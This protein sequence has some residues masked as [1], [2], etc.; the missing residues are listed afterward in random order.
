MTLRSALPALVAIALIALFYRGLQLGDPGAIESPFLGKPAPELD[1]ADLV[2]PATRIAGR[3]LAGQP[4]VL[5][6]WGT[7]CP[8]C[9]R[10][11]DVLLQ[12]AA[13]NIVPVIGLN[14]RDERDKAMAYLARAGN[15]F[16]RVGS[17]PDGRNAID[18]GVYGAPE[19]FL[20]SA[21]GIVLH[22]H[23]GALTWEAWQR[24]FLS[25]LPAG[26]SAGIRAPGAATVPFSSGAKSGAR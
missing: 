16:A 23:I 7:W 18:W 19:T 26:A 17:D 5:N 4:Y 13:Q 22:K 11:H 1:M 15:P 8:E 2:E 6:V 25:R 3:D 20:I 14:W 10:E 21:E 9:Y 12:I 24:D